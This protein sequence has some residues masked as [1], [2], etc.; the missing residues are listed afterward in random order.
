MLGPAKP[1]EF[2]PPIVVSLESLVPRDHVSRDL[3]AHLD[4]S[5]VRDWVKGCYPDRGRPSI[6]PVVFCKR[7]LVMVFEGI[8]SERQL[9]ALAVDRLSVRWYLGYNLDEA[10]PDAS[11]FSRIRQ[12][13]GLDVFRRFFEQ[14]VDLCQDA[15]LVW[16]K[17][18]LADATRVPGNAAMD[19]PVPRLRDVVD[20]HVV[21]LFAGDAV[22]AGAD[23][24]A[25]DGRGRWDLLE[26]CRLDPAAHPP[27]RTVG[28]P[29]A[30]SAAPT[31]TRPRWPCGTG[32]PFLD[33]RI[34]P[35]S[36][37]AKP[38]SSSIAW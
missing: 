10:L 3:D 24:A 37:A 11:S 13:L 12:R 16:G 7:S 33:I 38:G 34:T 9:L 22:P 15:G 36:T 2:G 25:R 32:A 20:D 26:A 30:R 18:V 8:R 17:E 23:D 6:D 1:C 29:P 5:F 31:Q 21:A 4:L 27:G 19:S 28:S 35:W 14:V